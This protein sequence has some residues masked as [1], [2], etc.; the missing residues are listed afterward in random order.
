[1]SPLPFSVFFHGADQ[2]VP[3]RWERAGK[4]RRRRGPPA[5]FLHGT[6]RTMSSFVKTF[7]PYY[8]TMWKKSQHSA[9]RFFF[10]LKPDGVVF[11]RAF[12]TFK[13]VGG[14]FF[15]RTGGPELLNLLILLIFRFALRPRGG[16]YFRTHSVFRVRDDVFCGLLARRFL[17]CYFFLFSESRSGRA[18]A[19]TFG[20]TASFAFGTMFFPWTFSPATLNQ[21]FLLVFRFALRPRGGPY[22]R[23][24]TDAKRLTRYAALKIRNRVS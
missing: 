14:C 8:K 18:R 16:P 4:S 19:R 2:P 10:V 15:L 20:R 12:Y 13:H 3:D 11:P 22:F 23:N 9:K 24:Q 5:E 21:L 17:T 6:D 7:Q 1:M